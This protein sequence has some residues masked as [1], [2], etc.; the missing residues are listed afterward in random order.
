M[1]QDDLWNNLFFFFFPLAWQHKSQ[2]WES[3]WPEVQKYLLV[4]AQV[5]KKKSPGSDKDSS[6]KPA[7]A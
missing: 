7:S 1:L 3:T 4:W 6:G 5:A 2:K